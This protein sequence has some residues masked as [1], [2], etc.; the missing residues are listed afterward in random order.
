[1]TRV[2][3]TALL[4]LGMHRS[5]TSALTGVI[6]LMGADLP[7]DL[8][9]ASDLNAKG[10]F[11][12]NRI[13]G[14]DEDLLA[15]AGF[16]WWD[17]RRFPPDWFASPKA[18][19]FARRAAGEL[20]AEY[21][22]SA[23]FVLKDPR[24]C[25]LAPFW[26]PVLRDN[27]CKP[28]VILPLRHPRDV[29]ASLEHRAG[30]DP[31]YGL[32]MWLRHVLDAEADT[33][34]TRRV[35]TSYEALMTDWS[36]EIR[37]IGTALGLSWPRSLSVAGPE[38]DAFLSRDLQH[39]ARTGVERGSTMALPA[40]VRK[41][42]EILGTWT[43][44][45]ERPAD[46]G[47]LDKLRAKL[48]ASTDSF[49]GLAR[50]GEEWRNEARAYRT[51][52][53][54]L[55]GTHT[56]Q[57]AELEAAKARIGLLEPEVDR[58]RAESDA[59]LAEAAVQRRERAEEFG[60][61]HARLA[62]AAQR[63]TEIDR[64]RA[65]AE[66]AATEARTNLATQAQAEAEAV[67]AR[68]V[69]AAQVEAAAEER[70]RLQAELAAATLRLDDLG[71]ELSAANVRLARLDEVEV[72]LH[73]TRSALLQREEETDQLRRRLEVLEARSYGLETSL[74]NALKAQ[75]SA[76]HGHARAA[77]QLARLT[78]Q[79]TGIMQ[80][81][82]SRRLAQIESE[83]RVEPGASDLE[84]TIPMSCPDRDDADAESQSM[85]DSAE[86]SGLP[87]SDETERSAAIPEAE[88][89]ASG[90]PPD[91]QEDPTRVEAELA[92][93]SRLPDSAEV[94]PPGSGPEVLVALTGPEPGDDEAKSQALTAPAEASDTPHPA[95]V[96]SS[97]PV[98]ESMPRKAQAVQ[99]YR[100]EPKRPHDG[101]K[102][103]FRG[104]KRLWRKA[105]G[106]GVPRR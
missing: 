76:E 24:I 49:G 6:G 10:F 33:R 72:E 101:V 56:R 63:L 9:A 22:D 18:G 96:P 48:D 43:R 25:R 23:L 39:F 36:A 7:N 28:R 87:D 74:D 31:D 64:L 12:S 75:A 69:L 40:L 55:S 34:G 105:R 13:T 37:R 83:A 27:G 45:G 100:T 29:A 71:T 89:A 86:V 4:V 82:V 32:L 38:I 106:R 19:E 67:A 14:F 11:E 103:P 42:Y 62:E 8:M 16:T 21:G 44:D 92:E 60:Q 99:S 26:L 2:R 104:L 41:A 98:P 5:G 97:A 80:R 65:A 102:P 68:T 70:R 52:H 93:V 17:C 1:M 81:D 79:M 47:R 73:Q 84:V 88:I 50:R 66:A 51:A 57:T 46:H 85:A 15:S 90:P 35:F 94:H 59:L 30:Y 53:H 20:A 54:D 58:L 95:R 61:L 77:R 3:R 91:A 78:A